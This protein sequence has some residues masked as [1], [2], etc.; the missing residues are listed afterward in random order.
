MA[1]PNQHTHT[2]RPDESLADNARCLLYGLIPMP[3]DKPR[4]IVEKVIA[5]LLVGVWS[6][7]FLGLSFDAVSVS[8][9]QYWAIFTAIVFTLV[10]KLWDLEVEKYLPG[11]SKRSEQSNGED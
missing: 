8:T 9:P 5:L 4:R 10:G 7:V 6:T 2:C 3:E 1:V 11:G